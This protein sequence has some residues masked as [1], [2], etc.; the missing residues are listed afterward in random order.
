MSP[1]AGNLQQSAEQVDVVQTQNGSLTQEVEQIQPRPEQPVA[2]S[3]LTTEQLERIDQ[4]APEQK[5]QA[6]QSGTNSVPV[7]K[8]KQKI[9]KY[10]KAR[11]RAK[12][13]FPN[14]AVARKKYQIIHSPI[15]AEDIEIVDYNEERRKNSPLYQRLHEM[16]N[17]IIQSN[18]KTVTRSNAQFAIQREVHEDGTIK[19]SIYLI[20][21]GDKDSPE[22][23]SGIVAEHFAR[24][25]S[26]GKY[27]VRRHILVKDEKGI[28][29]EKGKVYRATKWY[30]KKKGLFFRQNTTP[31]EKKTTNYRSHYSIN[32]PKLNSENVVTDSLIG[33]AAYA[34]AALPAG[35][36]DWNPKNKLI[37]EDGD[38]LSIDNS[39][40]Q[41]RRM[42]F[43]GSA[44]TKEFLLY[45]AGVTQEYSTIHTASSKYEEANIFIEK[46]GNK[47]IYGISIGLL[48]KEGFTVDGFCDR[49]KLFY[50]ENF[51][52][53][54]NKF[55]EVLK[56]VLKKGKSEGTLHYS[57]RFDEASINEF[58]ESTLQIEKGKAIFKGT[59]K[60]GRFL[61]EV[62]NNIAFNLKEVEMIDNYIL[63]PFGNRLAALKDKPVENQLATLTQMY[64]LR[65]KNLVYTNYSD[66]E[67]KLDKGDTRIIKRIKK[68]INDDE[69]ES[70]KVKKLFCEYVEAQKRVYELAKDDEFR[71]TFLKKWEKIFPKDSVEYKNAARYFDSL[72]RN[73]DNSWPYVKRFH[74]YYD[75][76]T[77]PEELSNSDSDASNEKSTSD[78]TQN[79][80]SD[81][82]GKTNSLS[83]LSTDL[84][85]V[86][87]QLLPPPP[88]ELLQAV[89]EEAPGIQQSDMK[90]DEPA[91]TV[92]NAEVEPVKKVDQDL[93]PVQSK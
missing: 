43:I 30:S 23:P 5:Q 58:L 55:F 59:D 60:A 54:D 6:Q 14:D 1:A 12:E 75:D 29:G 77:S 62:F 20:K 24:I 80:G 27:S 88:Q 73:M 21:T 57:R 76:L 50:G 92:H 15:I 17:E 47:I 72:R 26:D 89:P 19:E 8:E 10:Q 22:S 38:L 67:I 51:P 32:D 44:F 71:R 90:G 64:R 45:L 16:K 37:N 48:P 28:I 34:G 83:A 31:Q 53:V 41:Y 87:N 11:K 61:Q 33:I 4:S 13:K 69:E 63:A 40:T 66:T 7:K 52:E 91:S 2:P 39:F 18:S 56:K 42:D 81:S 82:S 78:K 86:E 36:H 9:S 68:R 3:S 79:S 49:L 93:V 74:A 70:E 65:A 46:F 35:E 84:A 85:K 25:V